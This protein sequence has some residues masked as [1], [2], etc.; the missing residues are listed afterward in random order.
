VLLVGGMNAV[1][2]AVAANPD[3]SRFDGAPDMGLADVFSAA[4]AIDD[5]DAV[6]VIAGGGTSCASRVSIGG[7]GSA[8]DPTPCG[9]ASNKKPAPKKIPTVAAPTTPSETR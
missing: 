8:E 6:S 3:A 4:D 9:G 7:T 2:I 5:P 1:S